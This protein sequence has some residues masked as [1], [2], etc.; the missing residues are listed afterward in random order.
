MHNGKPAFALKATGPL[1]SATVE[2]KNSPTQLKA[3][4]RAPSPS[5]GPSDLT[6]AP[7]P[8]PQQPLLE[9]FQL[10][11]PDTTL[12]YSYKF[13]LI[14]KAARAMALAT[15]VS[16]RGDDQGV[17][18][19]QFMIE[20]EGGKVSFVEFHFVPLVEEEDDGDDDGDEEEEEDEVEED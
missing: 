9:T 8:T 17:L 6:T 11:D 18:S 14:Q 12:R 2:F 19:L 10:S 4:N 13:S 5:A 3:Q 20:V 15:K 16:V 7:P 1:G